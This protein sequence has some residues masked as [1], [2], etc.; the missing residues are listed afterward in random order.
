MAVRDQR[1][2]LAHFDAIYQEGS[3]GEEIPKDAPSDEGQRN[4]PVRACLGVDLL[5]RL[6]S[7]A[8]NNTRSPMIWEPRWALLNIG[9]IGKR[10]RPFKAR[11]TG[12]SKRV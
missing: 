5:I 11:D 4:L 8:I 10:E 9:F 6:C 2:V 12:C 3:Q 7:S 1:A